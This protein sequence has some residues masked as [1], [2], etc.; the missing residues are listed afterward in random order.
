[1]SRAN[2]KFYI[3]TSIAYTNAKS[4]IGF[5]LEIIQA[6]VVARYRR[7]L[8]DDVWFLTGVDEH[9]SKIAR[10]AEEFGKKPQEFV[11]EISGKFKKLKDVLNLTND[12]FIRTTDQK[13]HWPTVH[14]VWQQ[15]KDNGDIYK[16]KYEG[17][18]CAGCE[19]FKKEK[20]LVEWFNLKGLAEK[21][22]E[23][24]LYYFRK[25]DKDNLDHKHF[26]AFLTRYNNLI[27]RAMLKNLFLFV[28][29]GEFPKELKDIIRDF[30]IPRQTGRKKKRFPNIVSMGEV[31]MIANKM[32]DRRN[33]I[34]VLISFYCGLRP[35]EL[36]Q[37]EVNHINWGVW[38]KDQSKN[39]EIRVI[40]KGNKERKLPIMKDIMRYT[41]WWIQ[42]TL[43]DIK[44]DERLFK[45]CDRHWRDRKSTRLNSSHIPLSRMPSS[46]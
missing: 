14:K 45:I 38:L 10:K 3:T 7:Q 40:G 19:C 42:E 13:R 37:I 9:G 17:L 35:F 33:E 39:G 27:A 8:G 34:M 31:N 25:L 24:Y 18:Y 16:K 43:P 46:A 26:I 22:I 21:S 23:N 41:Y 4:H 29:T 36:L 1:M 15:L 2:K 6:D 11:D 12:D 20:D 32:K 44:P 5:A 28:K 30:D